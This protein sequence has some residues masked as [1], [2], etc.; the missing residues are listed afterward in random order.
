MIIWLFWQSKDVQYTKYHNGMRP[1]GG[2]ASVV[3]M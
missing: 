3:V 1:D 2:L